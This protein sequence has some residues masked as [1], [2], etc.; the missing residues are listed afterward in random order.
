MLPGSHKL[1]ENTCMSLCCN[2]LSQKLK[3]PIILKT[4]VN[5]NH[6][7]IKLMNSLDWSELAILAKPDLKRTTA[8]LKWVSPSKKSTAFLGRTRVHGK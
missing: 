8:K 5:P 4:M 1:M 7:L 3:E 2:G 6:P